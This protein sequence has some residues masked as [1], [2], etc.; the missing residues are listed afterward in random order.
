MIHRATLL[1]AILMTLPAMPSDAGPL[2]RFGGDT[3]GGTRGRVIR[4]TTLNAKGP[5]SLRDALAAK[6]P[7]IVEFA[8]GGVIDLGRESL[9]ITEP[10]V[11]VR[12]ETAPSPGITL[13]RGEIFINTNDVILRHLRVRPGDAGRKGLDRWEPDGITCSGGGAR[14]ILI[15]HCSITWAVDENIAI[16]GPR[17]DGPEETAGSITI[18]NCIIAEALSHATH[19][20]DEHSKGMLIHDNCREVAVIGNLF[21]HNRDRNPYYKGGTSGIVVNNVIY[22]PGYAAVQTRYLW[23]QY[24][25][26]GKLPKDARVGVVGNLLIH[27]VDSE[28]NLALVTGNWRRA[29]LYLD[30]NKAV[31]ADD[32]R[33]EIVDFSY[34]KLSRDAIMP[35]GLTIVPVDRVLDHVI[36]NAGARSQD[37]DTIDR[38]IIEDLKNRKGRIIDSQ[39]E[40]GGYPR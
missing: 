16:S 40:V 29:E 3:T 38:R 27:G 7:R 32:S 6:G 23:S 4:V 26:A 8:V 31:K 37:R 18:R 9:R 2:A 33:A 25:G 12:G 5:G 15:E 35:K 17:H 22:N 36:A 11:T 10:N 24:L 28:R 14:N 30:A 13:I 19:E 34:E 21:A 39:D 1:A 20:E